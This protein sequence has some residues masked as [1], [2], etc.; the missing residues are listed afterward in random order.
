MMRTT[1]QP[2]RFEIAP[3]KEKCG[4]ARPHACRLGL[5]VSQAPDAPEAPVTVRD[6]DVN[7]KPSESA[8]PEDTT[9]APETGEEEYTQIDNLAGGSLEANTWCVN[10]AP[11]SPFPRCAPRA[12]ELWCQVY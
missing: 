12:A 10:L 8:A 6:I 7:R 1:C 2:S 3:K 5:R 11:S 4:T 9:P